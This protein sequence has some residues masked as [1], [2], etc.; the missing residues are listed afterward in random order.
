MLACP[1]CSKEPFSP[2]SI[3]EHDLDVMNMGH[4]KSGENINV[5]IKGPILLVC[6]DCEHPVAHCY[7]DYTT[8]IPLRARSM[9]DDVQRQRYEMLEHKL[10]YRDTGA[11]WK[12]IQVTIRGSFFF[13]A[14]VAPLSETIRIP[15]YH[16]HRVY[17]L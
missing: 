13:L 1:K 4:D 3:P 7:L 8:T 14:Q 5:N 2:R 6:V 11:G 10:R 17:G 12:H 15:A 16:F 9:V